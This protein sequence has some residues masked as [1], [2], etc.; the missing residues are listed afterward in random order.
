[1]PLLTNPTSCLA[2]QH[3]A[4]QYG[5]QCRGPTALNFVLDTKT[6]KW[7]QLPPLPVPRSN[8]TQGLWVWVRGLVWHFENLVYINGFDPAPKPKNSDWVCV[9]FEN[10]GG[11]LQEFDYV[12][13]ILRCHEC[14]LDVCGMPHVILLNHYS[15]EE[16]VQNASTNVLMHLYQDGGKIPLTDRDPRSD[17]ALSSFGLSL[18]MLQRTLPNFQ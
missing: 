3:A 8:V 14:K 1:M 10:P 9:P 5:P 2:L 6:K 15:L 4:G 16:H 17:N 18:I 11:R 12:S 7:S 13:Q